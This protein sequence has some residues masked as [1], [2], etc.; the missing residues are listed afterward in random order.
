M[1]KGISLVGLILIIVAII[2][3]V[4]FLNSLNEKNVEENIVENEQVIPEENDVKN[5]TEEIE[6]AS[7]NDLSLY[8]DS[9]YSG[10][11][12]NLYPS[13]E[14]QVIDVTDS[15][16]VNHMTGLKNGDDL[17]YLVVSEP[18]MSS[19]AYSLVI[20][21]VKTGVSADS[22]AKTMIDNIDTRKWICVEAEK[23]YATS[24]GNI[25]FL[26]MSSEE[27]AKPVYEEFK[28]RAGTIGEEYEKTA[29]EVEL[30]EEMY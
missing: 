7:E 28:N 18:M 21:K 4:L 14:N 25:V 15:E 26:V 17:E 11:K 12:G 16:T 19:Q 13:L 27:M 9:L 23:V 30:P 29:E 10:I 2:C 8:V 3:C 1:K 22:I 6:I 24:S 5:T 20:A